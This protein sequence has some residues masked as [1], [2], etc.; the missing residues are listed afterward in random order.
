M[1]EPILSKEQNK[2]AFFSGVLSLSIANIIVKIIGLLFKIPIANILSQESLGS[3]VGLGY[4]SASYTVY[5]WLFM[6]ATAG[7]PNGISIVIAENRAAGRREESKRIFRSAM[8]LFF[9]IGIFLTA[10][11]LL[12]AGGIADLIKNPDARFSMMAIAPTLLFVCL[13]SVF[14]GYFYGF[15]EMLP[16]AVSEVI[17]AI[18]KLVF[19]IGGAYYAYRMGYSAPRVAAYAVF[20]VTAG[21]FLGTLFLFVSYLYYNK[22]SRFLITPISQEPAGKNAL[23]R[24]FALSVP[25]TVASS[26]MSLTGLIDVGT[27]MSRLQSIGYTEA[28]SSALYG[29]YTMLA[30]PIYNLPIVLLSPISAAILPLISG[31]LARGDEKGTHR[32]SESALRLVALFVIPSALGIAAFSYPILA[33]LYEDNAAAIA[34]PLLS[35]LAIATFFLGLLTVMNA[36]LQAHKLAGKTLIAMLS[37]AVVKLASGIFLVGKPSIG[38]YGVPLS[39]VLC[40]MTIVVFDTYYFARYLH[41][42]PRFPQLLIRP[43]CAGGIAILPVKFLLY[44]YLSAHISGGIATLISIAAVSVLYIIFLFLFRA[45]S[46]ADI[47]LLPNGERISGFL[48]KK[49]LISKG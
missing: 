1:K 42:M 4:F 25:I 47:L 12:F 40:Y 38:M 18:G 29:T 16:S 39:T 8:L 26:V 37:G 6:V 5:T 20:G 36:V 22:R 33:L 28:E 35:I 49:K 30:V 3:G 31:K 15:Q 32:I 7:L 48:Q 13:L 43:I 24:V 44:P 27:M 2:R 34:A 46:E 10:I 11:M 45:V 14:R 23:R 19:G 41:I 21:V 9:V 17:E